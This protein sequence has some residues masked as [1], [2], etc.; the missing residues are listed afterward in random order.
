MM[1]KKYVDSGSA[2]RSVGLP[3]PSTK[4]HT[5]I[6]GRLR[7]RKRT[8]MNLRS[9]VDGIERG[10]W[11]TRVCD[12]SRCDYQGLFSMFFGFGLYR[13][14]RIGGGEGCAVQKIGLARHDFPQGTGKVWNAQSN[15]DK[16]RRTRVVDSVKRL[17]DLYRGIRGEDVIFL[18]F[19][20]SGCLRFSNV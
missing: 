20:F 18:V 9:V 13:Y 11:I 7:S 10:L 6:V 12:R 15:Q 5:G 2:L 8:E 4:R 19:R 16:C 3:M 17:Q 1:A 14:S